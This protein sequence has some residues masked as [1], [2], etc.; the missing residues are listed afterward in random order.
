MKKPIFA[1]ILSTFVLSLS[2]CAIPLFR[3][4]SATP[5]STSDTTSTGTSDTSTTS[6][7]SADPTTATT[8]DPTSS[9]GKTSSTSG[10]TSTT[11]SSKPTSATSE[12]TSTPSGEITKTHLKYDYNDWEDNN[13]YGMMNCPT[14][15]TPKVLIIPIW[16]TDSSNYIST[17]GKN[18]VKSDIEKAYLGSNSDVGWRSVKTYYEELS[19]GKLNLQGTVADWYE[20]GF[21]S[22]SCD[23]NDTASLVKNASN[24]YFS[25]NPSDSRRNYDSD[26]D[27]Y[28]DAVLLIYGAPD[29]D[30]SGSSNDNLWAYCSWLDASASKSSPQPVVFFWASYDFMYSSSTASS[31]TGKSSYGRGDTSHC[32]LDTHTFIHEMGHVLGLDDYYDYSNQYTPAGSFSMQDYNVGSHDPFSVMAYG[33]ADPYI[34]TTTMTIELKPFQSS[35]DIILLST[36]NATVDSPFDEYFLLELYTPTGLN[37]F[38]S[39]NAYRGNYPTGSSKAGIRLWHIDSRLTQYT[40]S[41]WSEN[42]ITDPT[43]GN[44]YNACSNTYYSSD[45]AD[46]CSVLGSNYYNLN[47]LQLIRNYSSSY[48]PTDDFSENALFMAGDTFS[49]SNTKYET[50]FYNSG[51]M[52]SN[53]SLGWTFTVDS[54]SSSGASI[55]VTK[56]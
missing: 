46:Y 9:T 4:T 11:S 16:F 18:N 36:H 40:R 41:G 6:T 45:V 17:S 56:L 21:T 24:D 53:T 55:T 30:A 49:M 13:A 8:S 14:I 27:G 38:D 15:G 35:K 52:N 39:T 33:W 7:T 50:Q 44:I 2:S 51:K 19:G 42:L 23:Q 54:C 43:K 5:T 25:N 48:K 3:P 37:Q 26:G 31:R 22:S 12:S 20:A 10:R 29:Y 47:L 28:L 34:P 32:T 1:V